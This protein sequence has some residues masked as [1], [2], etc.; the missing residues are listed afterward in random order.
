[1]M[2]IPTPL[3]KPTLAELRV[4]NQRESLD[5]ITTC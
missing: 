1:M 4:P 3:H 5:A 2:D